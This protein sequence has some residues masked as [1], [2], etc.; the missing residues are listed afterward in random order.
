MTKMT[1]I[2]VFTLDEC[3]SIATEVLKLD[4]Y[5]IDRGCFYTLGAAT[6]QDSI[7]TYPAIANAFNLIINGAFGLMHERVNDKLAEHFN[8][9]VGNMDSGVGLP[10]F[11]V[12]DSGSNGMQGHPHIDEPYTRVDF[13]MLEWDNPFSFTLPVSIPSAGAG[14]DFW[15]GCSDEEID[16]YFFHGELPE[17]EYVPYK[18]GSMYVHDGKTPHRIASIA[19]IPENETRITLQGHGVHVKDGIIVYF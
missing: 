2:D 8:K 19:P 17:P 13:S 15:W 9:P 6:Y 18:L 3:E 4:P 14:V 1:I 7:A 10:S 16:N 11:H 12:F 5:L